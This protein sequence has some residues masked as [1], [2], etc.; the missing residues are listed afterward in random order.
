MAE[1][2]A[3]F[4]GELDEDD[5]WLA[6]AAG[7]AVAVEVEVGLGV[8]V[9]SSEASEV[10]EAPFLELLR[11]RALRCIDRDLLTDWPLDIEEACRPS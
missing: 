7:V 11:E 6:C 3:G 5:G 1:V 4:W 2:D 9:A 8:E 10:S